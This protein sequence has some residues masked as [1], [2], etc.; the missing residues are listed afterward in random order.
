LPYFFGLGFSLF[1]NSEARGLAQAVDYLHS[2]EE[3]VSSNSRTAEN[4]KRRRNKI[5]GFLKTYYADIHYK[6]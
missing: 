5:D 3:A 2:K 4:K 1:Q 6:N